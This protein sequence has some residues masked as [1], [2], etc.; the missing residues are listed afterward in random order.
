MP[1]YDAD[2][3]GK[4]AF[5]VMRIGNTTI[6]VTAHSP[7]LRIY[8]VVADFVRTVRVHTSTGPQESELV[9]ASSVPAAIKWKR[10]REK[11]LFDKDTHLLDAAMRCRMIPGVTVTTKDRIRFNGDTYEIVDVVDVRNLHL[12]MAIDLRKVG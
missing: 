2:D 8:N 4:G 11:V 12:L 9:L 10:G 6:G 7:A 5:R 3:S 1:L